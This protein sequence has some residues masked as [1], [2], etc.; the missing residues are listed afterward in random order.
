M[1]T[2]I[3]ML[4]GINVGGRN[5]IKMDQLKDLYKSLG[6]ANI[7]SYIQSGNIIFDSTSKDINGIAKNVHQAIKQTFGYDVPVFIRTANDFRLTIQ[8]NPFTDKDISKLQITFLSGSPTQFSIDEINKARHKS[9][10]FYIFQRDV[11]LF[12]PLG[13]GISKLSNTFF[14]RKLK[15]SATTRNWKTVNKLMELAQG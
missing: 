8:N 4:R 6:F 10:E 12:C 2:Y 9:E 7:H 11:Y 13:Y 14:E 1:I 5:K 3:S 15:T